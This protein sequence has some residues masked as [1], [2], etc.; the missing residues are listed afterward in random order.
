MRRS[1]PLVC[2]LLPVLLSACASAPAPAP[3]PR[4]ATPSTAST[5][6]TRPPAPAE[7]PTPAVSTNLG[8]VIAASWSDLPEW[9]QIELE[10]SWIA[11]Q[12]SCRVLQKKVDWQTVCQLAAELKKPDSEQIRQF[13]ERN[14]LPWQMRQA[15]GT[16]NG[17]VTG[18]Y[19]P[20]LRGALQPGG[21]FVHGVYGVPD[22]MITVDLASIY[23]QLKGLRLRGRIE[24]K[25]LVPYHTR[26]ELARL[27][28]APLQGRALAWVSDPVE[29]AFLQI[30]GSG[31]IQL[32]D[33]KMLRVGYADQNGHPWK[34]MARWLIDQKQIEAH[35]ASMQAIQAWARANPQ[36]VDELLAADPS[37]VF[38]RQLPS[39]N[40]GPLGALGVP[41]TDSHSI[42]IDPRCIPLGTPV[43]L[44]TTWPADNSRP[45]NRLMLAQDTGGA[46]RGPVRADFFWGYGAEAGQLA[47]RMKQPG[48]MWLLWPLGSQPPQPG[49]F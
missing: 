42:A 39:N 46:I 27:D 23:P 14:F 41:L 6:A 3:A 7:T 17:L 16:D 32:P 34:S 15:D 29:L 5:P 9:P 10:G 36:R 33:G 49:S 38:F 8:S 45:L 26:A 28:Y 24:G 20:M 12:Q 2:L 18:Y 11:L 48:R 25:K 43:F 31:R 22:D 21:E 35:Q 40:D 44:S 19:E 13:F 37:Y 1:L 30:Q 47:G 4:P